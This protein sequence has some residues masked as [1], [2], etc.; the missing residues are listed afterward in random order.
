MTVGWPRGSEI[1]QY[2]SGYVD[3]H[4]TCRT[5]FALYMVIN[6]FGAEGIMM[7]GVLEGLLPEV[8]EP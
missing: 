3:Y 1:R 7:I 2:L 4:V 5:S 6:D 8:L